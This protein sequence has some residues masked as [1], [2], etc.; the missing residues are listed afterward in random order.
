MQFFS[1]RQAQNDRAV[2]EARRLTNLDL[3]ALPLGEGRDVPGVPFALPEYRRHR[4]GR[5]PVTL[6]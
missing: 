1:V 3:V 4:Y 6:P 5:P 2:R